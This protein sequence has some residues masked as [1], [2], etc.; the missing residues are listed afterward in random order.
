MTTE[1]TLRIIKANNGWIVSSF[2][3]R[4]PGSIALDTMV[5]QDDNDLAGVIAASLVAQKLEGVSN[6]TP[7]KPRSK[8]PFADSVPF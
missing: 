6:D 2:D 4:N 5:V 7:K 8:G 3:I 1:Y